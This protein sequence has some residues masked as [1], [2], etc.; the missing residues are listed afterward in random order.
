M[1]KVIFVFVICTL[2]LVGCKNE[3]VVINYNGKSPSWDVY[4]KIDGNEKSHDSYYTFIYTGINGNLVRDVKYSI[5]G[6]REGESGE[7]TYTDTNGYTNKMGITGGL[8][9]AT[10]RDIKVKVEWNGKTELLTLKRAK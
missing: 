8:P 4:Y 5:D 10:D 2:F 1:R 3:N 7:F 6:P 9:S